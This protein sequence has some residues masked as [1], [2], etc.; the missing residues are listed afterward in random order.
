MQNILRS[1][2]ALSFAATKKVSA[3][4]VGHPYRVIHVCPDTGKRKVFHCM[5]WE[6]ALEWIA[7]A[8]GLYACT[9]I[10]SNGCLV[11]RKTN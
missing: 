11:A 10:D 3:I 5:T 8:S 9:V 6:D 4:I 1:L 7:A 2:L